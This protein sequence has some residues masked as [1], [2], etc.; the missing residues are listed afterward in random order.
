MPGARTG[1]SVF[2]EQLG[3]RGVREPAVGGDEVPLVDAERLP[4]PML[5]DARISE[6]LLVADLDDV[7]VLAAADADALRLEALGL[8]PLRAPALSEAP[9]VEALRVE[10]Q[11]LARHEPADAAVEADCAEHEDNDAKRPTCGDHADADRRRDE[12]EPEAQIGALAIRAEEHRLHLSVAL[13]G[14]CGTR[15][16]RPR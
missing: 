2:L 16:R 9:Q 14:A 1:G 13:G 12:P 8:D 10:S 11:A 7:D 5:W 6:S 3:E 4:E 15:E